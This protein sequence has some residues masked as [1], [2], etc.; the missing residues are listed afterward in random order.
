MATVWVSVPL[1]TTTVFDPGGGPLAPRWETAATEQGGTMTVRSL[2]CLGTT[3]VRTPGIWS[4]VETASEDEEPPPQPVTATAMTAAPPA[5]T[6]P[7]SPLLID[8]P[9]AL[10]RSPVLGW[11]S[12]YPP[13]PRHKRPRCSA[14]P[15][16]VTPHGA[17]SRSRCLSASATCPRK[18][19][20]SWPGVGP[21]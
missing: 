1:G 17:S 6:S 20:G 5:R 11:G 4:A 9:P 12:H 3:T 21:V 18:R 13:P 7:A 19:P 10:V 14:A 16:A 2:C 8:S 15:T